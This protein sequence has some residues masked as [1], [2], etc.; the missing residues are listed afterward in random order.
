MS[1]DRR[2]FLA[3]TAA[4][5][6]SIFP[7][8]SWAADEILVGGLHDETGGLDFAGLPMQQMLRFAVGEINDGGGLLG[9][10][11][12]A[13]TADTGTN[14]QLYQSLAQQMALRDK[15]N[16]VQG[17]L[18]S[19]SREVIRP[20]LRRFKTLYFYNTHYEGGVCDRNCFC[21]GTTPA[22]TVEKLVPYVMKKWGKEVYTIAADYNYGQ[23]ISAWVKKYVEANGGRVL[24]TDFFPL[25]VTN[26]GPTI[27]KIQS[28]KPDLVMSVLVGAA[29]LGFYRQWASAGMKSKIP[30][31]ST[32]FGVGGTEPILITPEESN[33]IITC[34]GY[35][36]TVDTPANKAFVAK[37]QSKVGEYFGGK[38][39]LL[40]ELSECT[41][42]GVMMWAAAVK[43][44]GT[45]DRMKVIE[46]LESGMSFE[47][48]AGKVTIDPKTHHVTRD[49]HLADLQNRK[50][51]I[52]ETYKQ[53]PPADTRAVCDLQKDPNAN[54]HY[55]I[56]L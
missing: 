3:G 7:A 44:A 16:V 37:V 32:T 34:Y 25:D 1:V 15:V 28:A 51:I 14:M 4:A 41:Y 54:T 29:H 5:A 49:V 26:F 38:M 13:V 56:K 35:Y 45:V 47:F 42:E 12:R 40:T 20:V 11:V 22:Q 43:K 10:K 19:A 2:E 50:F 9:K 24:S 33:G 55:Q 52:L 30:M 23:I 8:L 21:T 53:Q 48:P 6:A 27:E 46:A 18:T 17:G 39:P 31:A 36:R